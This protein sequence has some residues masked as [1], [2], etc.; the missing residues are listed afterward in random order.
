MIEL[1]KIPNTISRE[2]L[3]KENQGYIDDIKEE[4]VKN[5]PREL[6]DMEFRLPGIEY[7]HVYR[8]NMKIG[9]ITGFPQ[10]DYWIAMRVW[11]K[12]KK[13]IYFKELIDKVSKLKTQQ[14]YKGLI[15]HPDD[16]TASIY[17]K[18]NIAKEI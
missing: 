9:F 4:G 5:S 6:L 8:N 18:H 16:Y 11:L 7:Y 1:L 12:G 2:V 13:K 15:A 10:D 3:I 17:D 14:G